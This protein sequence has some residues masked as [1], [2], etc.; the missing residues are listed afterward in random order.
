MSEVEQYTVLYILTRTPDLIRTNINGCDPCP[1]AQ[2]QLHL[3][4]PRPVLGRTQPPLPAPWPQE[5]L[6]RVQRVL[7]A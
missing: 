1:F 5:V 7:E 3:G 4:P 6:G 2:L